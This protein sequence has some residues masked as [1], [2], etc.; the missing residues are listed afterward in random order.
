MNFCFVF[1]LTNQIY[2]KNN[3]QYFYIKKFIFYF[4]QYPEKSV[5]T[6]KNELIPGKVGKYQIKWVNTRKSR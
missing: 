5:N 6:G 1:I 2:K 3:Y 4:L